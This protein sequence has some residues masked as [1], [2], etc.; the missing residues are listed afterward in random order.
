MLRAEVHAHVERPPVRREREKPLLN[1]RQRLAF[2]AVVDAEVVQTWRPCRCRERSREHASP[3]CRR[4]DECV[5][6]AELLQAVENAERRERVLFA[7][8]V[9]AKSCGGS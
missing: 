7:F 3:K 2:P 5:V 9:S 8:A 6:P 1:A 4:P